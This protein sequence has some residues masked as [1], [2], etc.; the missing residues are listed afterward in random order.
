MQGETLLQ[1]EAGVR[2]EQCTERGAGCVVALAPVQ[3]TDPALC[4]IVSAVPAQRC[5]FGAS[6]G[7]EVP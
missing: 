2:T 3:V 1:P 5:R 4:L 7:R 6:L